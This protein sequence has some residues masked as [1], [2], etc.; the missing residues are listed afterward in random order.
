MVM[1]VTMECGC[2]S[3]T[4]SIFDTESNENGV[5]IRTRFYRCAE[6]NDLHQASII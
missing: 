6:C 4:F 3:K 5:V 2:G 1:D